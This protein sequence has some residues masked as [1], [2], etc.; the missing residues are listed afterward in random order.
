MRNVFEDPPLDRRLESLESLAGSAGVS[1]VRAVVNSETHK[2]ERSNGQD[3][4]RR[5]EP[6]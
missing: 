3:F 2:T 4:E 5:Q 1:Q 6:W